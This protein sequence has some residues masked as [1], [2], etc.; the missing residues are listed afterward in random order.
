MY[1]EIITMPHDKNPSFPARDADHVSDEELHVKC[2]CG[3]FMINVL[4]SRVSSI[5]CDCSRH[6]SIMLSSH[7]LFHIYR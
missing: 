2:C 7:S 4:V 3:M 1:N 6:L 5:S